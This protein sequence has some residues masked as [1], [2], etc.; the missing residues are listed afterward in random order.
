MAST[1]AD[2][3]TNAPNRLP[4]SASSSKTPLR[5]PRFD[6]ADDDFRVR[7][8]RCSPTHRATAGSITSASQVALS[9]WA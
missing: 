3:L 8:I 1:C 9:A 7:S 5:S 6:R 4:N 2:A